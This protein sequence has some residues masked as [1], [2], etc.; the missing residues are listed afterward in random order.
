M[1]FHLIVVS[2]F[3]KTCVKD[4]GASKKDFI[5]M[6]RSALVGGFVNILVFLNKK[7]KIKQ[8]KTDFIKELRLFRLTV[9]RFLISCKALN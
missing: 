5:I 8:R 9:A 6:Y 4:H 3:L 2:N 7:A 1:L